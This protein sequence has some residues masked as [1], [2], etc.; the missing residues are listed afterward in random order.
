MESTIL[1]HSFTIGTPS[2]GG[3]I[4]IYFN[5][6]HDEQ[7]AKDIDKA[8]TIWK[9]LKVITGKEKWKNYT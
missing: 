3:A 6:I 1:Q 9:N 7:T 8:I 4:K 5:N 2:G